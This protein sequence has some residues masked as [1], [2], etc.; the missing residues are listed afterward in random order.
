MAALLAGQGLERAAYETAFTGL[1]G[2]LGGMI[3]ALVCGLEGVA[4]LGLGL[5][6]CPI[7][8]GVFGLIFG[9]AGDALA[10]ASADSLGLT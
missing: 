8:I 1:V 10:T 4:T 7:I 5:L 2:I 6:T 9:F 3:G